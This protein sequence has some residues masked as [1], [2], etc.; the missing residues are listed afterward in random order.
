MATNTD[1]FRRRVQWIGLLGGPASAL[2][3]YVFLPTQYLGP[4]GSLVE[5]GDAGRM[6]MAVMAWMAVWWLTEAVDL[7]VTALVPVTFFPLLGVADIQQAAAPY[8][9]PLIFLFMGGFLIAISMQKWGLDRRIAL[10]TLK[11]VGTRPPNMVAGFMVT[12]A[13]LSAFVSNTATTA[14][15]VPI[16]LSV[17]H[18]VRRNQSQDEPNTADT[19]NQLAVCLLLGIAYAASLGGIA[20]IIGTPPNAL[21]VAFVSS[22]I[23]PAYRMEISFDRWLA[24]GLPVAVVF[25]PLVW[26]LL[27]RLL[28]RLSWQPIR[29]G[30]ELIRDELKQLGPPNAG[31]RATFVVFSIT[32]LCWINRP[33]LMKISWQI[34][35]VVYEPFSGMTDAGIA[36]VGATS[37]FLIPTDIKRHVFALD[38]QATRQLPWGIL[39]LFGGGL[40]LASAV[41]TNGV[42]EFIGSLAHHVA[43][44]PAIAV[45]LAVTITVIFLTELTSNAA[46]TATLLPVLAALAP[47]M[48]LHPFLLILP[49]TIAASCAFMM[50]VATPP[51]AIV[52]GSGEI[53]MGQMMRAGIALNLV[54]I[55]LV[56]ILTMLWY[57]RVFDLG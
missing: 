38:W 54:G 26:I 48:G 50:P 29:G 3:A 10:L 40:S 42:A 37:L 44:M 20:T 55:G 49:A 12:T 4:D 43:G 32:A 18:L 5:F 14:M 8:A 25:L 57:T 23:E 34:G 15:M 24:V 41:K 39:I 30:R 36:M 28:F 56:T 35:S 52:F 53:R 22:S 46:T 11:N 9:H 2:L 6:T 51:N 1:R 19:A 45:V 16:A 33:L 17:V 21:L 7:S 27:T 31:E 13:G 47:G